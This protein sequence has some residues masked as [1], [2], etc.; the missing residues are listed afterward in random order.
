MPPR[1]SLRIQL[2]PPRRSAWGGIASVLLHLLLLVAVVAANW[3]QVLSWAPVTQLGNPNEA[4]GGGGGGGSIRPVALPA[5][6]RPS[7]PSVRERPRE[8]PVIAP[9]VVTPPEP[10]VVPPPAE[11]AVAISA[12][13][14]SIPSASAGQGGPGMGGGRGS[15]IGPGQGSGVG[16]GSG[17]GTGPGRGGAGGRG[18]PPEPRQVILPP[19]DYPGGLRGRTIAV[20]FWVGTDGRVERVALDPEI[21]DRGFARK[22][23]E[24]MKNY[25]FRPARS[26]DGVAIAG[27]TTVSVTF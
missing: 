17:S 14:D 24:V 8:Q 25:R 1:P 6:E 27:T 5:F 15:G 13:P 20:T 22:F 26:P 2:P 23:A 12:A 16:P 18:T 9:P 11:P 3:R 21:E 4:E 10:E 19:L 7:A